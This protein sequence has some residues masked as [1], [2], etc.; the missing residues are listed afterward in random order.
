MLTF[1]LVFLIASLALAPSSLVFLSAGYES[2]RNLVALMAGTSAYSLMAFN[3][4]LASRLPG[5]ERVLGG[6]DQ[7]YKA[8]KWSGIAVLGLIL[9]HTQLKFIQLE[10][11]VPPG[12]LA[13]TAV[14]V[15]KPAFMV[16]VVVILISAVKRVPRVR[17]ELPWMWWRVTHWLIV[18]I[19]L[20]LSFHQVFVKAPFD[21]T[22][23]I[24]GW[25]YGAGLAGLGA[26][27]WIILAPW[28]RK[29]PYEVVAVKKL[30]EATQ[31]TARPLRRPVKALAGQFAFLSAARAGLR[32]PHPFTLSRLGN[33][34][35]VEFCIQ[36]AGD[37]TRR[38]RDLLQPGD[39]L[40]IEGG[41]GRFDFRRGAAQ[42]I[43]LAG[44]IGITPF[45]AMA[46]AFAAVPDARSIVLIHAVRHV[47]LAIAGERLR[48]IAAAQ[49]GF[50][51]H[52]HDSTTKGRLDAEKL[53][54][55][56]PFSAIEA[57][58]WY[59][60][61]KALRLAILGQWRSQGKRPRSVHFEEFEFR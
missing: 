38:L 15:A 54:A 31:V 57:D 21:S 5:L 51:Y 61:P 6:L 49:A 13:E 47:D 44:G 36:P 50:A 9:V 25:L 23:A 40:R 8:H 10:G 1:R 60:G 37:F 2:A 24:R 59:C 55:Y 4:V 29:Y 52:L 12:S 7:I 28:L 35:E 19:F 41:Y 53:D 34:G 26:I 56:L 48:A 32:E 46:E 14:E 22:S 30:A 42:Q 11:L 45:L 20:V 33:G 39:R 3:L 27:I 43:W 17:A 16:L 58:L 18:P